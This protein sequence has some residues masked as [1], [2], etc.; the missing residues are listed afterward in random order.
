M[1]QSPFCSVF[2]LDLEW[3]LGKVPSLKERVE[4]GCRDGGTGRVGRNFQRHPSGRRIFS[5]FQIVLAYHI[6]PTDSENVAANFM[7]CKMMMTQRTG[8]ITSR[9][10]QTCSDIDVTYVFNRCSDIGFKKQNTTAV[11]K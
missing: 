6:K 4:G 1:G 3:P 7:F 10:T 11:C 2:W 5:S 9:E 8:D